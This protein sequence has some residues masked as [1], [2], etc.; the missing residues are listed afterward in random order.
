MKYKRL[1]ITEKSMRLLISI[2]QPLEASAE[3]CPP[4]YTR[5]RRVSFQSDKEKTAAICERLSNDAEAPSSSEDQT[6]CARAQRAAAG[7]QR[8][9]TGEGIGATVAVM[10]K[11]NAL[12][13]RWKSIK[14]NCLC[15][16]KMRASEGLD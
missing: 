8:S 14:Q 2:L 1:V 16:P 4:P 9:S 12:V 5:T 13:Q 15:G 6:L 3:R 7:Q 11:R 10:R